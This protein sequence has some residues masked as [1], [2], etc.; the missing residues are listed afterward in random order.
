MSSEIIENLS[1]IIPDTK[2]PDN[3]AFIGHLEEKYNDE[4]LAAFQETEDI[5]SG[6]INP[7]TYDNLPDAIKDLDSKEPNEETMAAMQE[8][9]DIASGKIKSKGYDDVDEMIQDILK[10]ED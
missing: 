7:K 2:E 1:G 5:A 9:E 3:A 6:K 4:T 8:A 10:D